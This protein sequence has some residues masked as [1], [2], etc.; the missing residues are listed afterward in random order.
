MDL[1]HEATH[2]ELPSAAVLRLAADQALGWL[3]AN[4]WQRQAEH[5]AGALAK[6]AELVQV[7]GGTG[8]GRWVGCVVMVSGGSR[9]ITSGYCWCSWRA[10]TLGKVACLQEYVALHAAAAAKV[11]SH[12]ADAGGSDDEEGGGPASAAAA[13][14]AAVASGRKGAA[15]PG[16]PA[17]GGCGTGGEAVAATAE[18]YSGAEGQRRRKAL[19]AELKAGV[20]RPAASLLVEPVLAAGASLRCCL[21][22]SSTG[23]VPS[24]HSTSAPAALT[25]WLSGLASCWACLVSIGSQGRTMKGRLPQ[26]WLASSTPQA[27]RQPRSRRRAGRQLQWRGRSPLRCPTF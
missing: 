5:L 19:L 11:A 2:N 24:G 4:Y 25:L 20:P 1:R 22:L 15:A 7:M 16:G 8:P 12:A 13:A 10:S 18:G 9:V 21:M 23:R 3:Q 27:C 26:P 6:V 14:A 17:K